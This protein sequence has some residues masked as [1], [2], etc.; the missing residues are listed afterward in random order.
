VIQKYELTVG[1]YKLNVSGDDSKYWCL[2]DTWEHTVADFY[3]L[4]INLKVA[5]Y[6]GNNYKCSFQLTGYPDCC[7][8]LIAHD[9]SDGC[10]SEER[11]MELALTF[12]AEELEYPYVMIADFAD[13]GVN[14]GR[15]VR[16]FLNP[17]S[18]EEIRFAILKVGE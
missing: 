17:R 9:F 6:K 15:Q 1:D 14:I 11:A 3:G 12:L 16:K 5:V 2:K 18:D 13:W 7:A 4:N 8:F 10:S